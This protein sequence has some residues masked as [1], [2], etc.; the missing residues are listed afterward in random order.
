LLIEVIAITAINIIR[1]IFFILISST[2][3]TMRVLGVYPASFVT[4][5]PAAGSADILS[6][7]GRRPLGSCRR[8][9]G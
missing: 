1:K 3:A 2:S 8:L 5:S 6:A 4:Q 9:A 7:S